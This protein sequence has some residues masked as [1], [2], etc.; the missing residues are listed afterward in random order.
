MWRLPTLAAA[1]ALL[2]AAPA[3]RAAD[4]ANGRG[5]ELW[6]FCQ[7]CHGADGG[8]TPLY[9]APSIAGLPTWYVERE[10][11]NF[12]EGIRG[13][14][15][16]DVSGMRMRPMALWLRTD[17]DIVAVA[18]YVASLPPVKPA[19]VLAGGSAAAGAALYAPC[20]ACHGADGRGNEQLGAPPLTHASDWYMLTQLQ[21]F[22]QGVRGSDPRDVKGALMVPMAKLLP[23]EQAMK[24]VIAYITTLEP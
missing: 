7:Q 8:G 17:A 24:N 14:H 9:L 15:F 4:E 19:P 11:R 6:G 18:G 12:H 23:D 5:R 1:L 13:T 10:L 3:G 2:L 16:D 22:K 21:H 20:I